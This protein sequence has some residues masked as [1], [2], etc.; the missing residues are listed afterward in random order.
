MKATNKFDKVLLKPIDFFRIHSGQELRSFLGAVRL[1]MMQTDGLEALKNVILDYENKINQEIKKYKQVY[2]FQTAKYLESIL[3]I[4]KQSKDDIQQAIWYKNDPVLLF[5]N[6]WGVEIEFIKW[7]IQYAINAINV[8]LK[9]QRYEFDSQNIISSYERSYNKILEDKVKNNMT[10]CIDFLRT[11][12]SEIMTNDPLILEKFNGYML[13]DDYKKIYR[14]LYPLYNK[15]GNK[16][17]DDKYSRENWTSLK[18]FGNEQGSHINPY[19]KKRNKVHLLSDDILDKI[20]SK[21]DEDELKKIPANF[22]SK[23][24]E[25]NS[26]ALDE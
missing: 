3:D 25:N 1:G 2:D 24:S 18:S 11:S 5:N 17:Y 16:Y 19:V 10:L 14:L 22:K 4:F 15:E 20:E 9:E 6:L 23:K 26:E 13:E 8:L 7:A 21:M 12:L